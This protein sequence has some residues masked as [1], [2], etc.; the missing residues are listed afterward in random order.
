MDFIKKA[1]E[2]LKGSSSGQPAAGN[3]GAAPQQGGAPAGQTQDYGDKGTFFSSISSTSPYLYL[4][5]S[6]SPHLP[7]H[8]PSP[9]CIPHPC[10]P[11][12]NPTVQ[13]ANPLPSIRLRIQEV[14]P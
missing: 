1:G 11:H 6:S 12:P 8:I 13:L 10:I 9:H 3:N 4:H 2:S 14:R 7:L 5:L